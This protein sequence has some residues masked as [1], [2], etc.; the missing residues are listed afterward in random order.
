VPGFFCAPSIKQEP[1]CNCGEDPFS[2][3]WCPLGHLNS[4]R[5]RTRAHK[6]NAKCNGSCR[7]LRGCQTWRR[8]AFPRSADRRRDW[9]RYDVRKG[10]VNRPWFVSAEI[11]AGS[12]ARSTPVLA[13]TPSPLASTA[14]QRFGEGV[15]CRRRIGVVSDEHRLYCR[16]RGHSPDDPWYSGSS[17]TFPILKAHEIPCA[18]W[19]RHLPLRRSTIH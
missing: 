10:S 2:L 19:S 4:P 5:F 8:G 18:L 14:E 1:G 3:A 6:C 7:R 17:L 16:P 11:R 9:H 13:S 15:G 12:P